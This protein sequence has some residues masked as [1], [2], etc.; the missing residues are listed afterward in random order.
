MT[1]HVQG[2]RTGLKSSAGHDGKHIPQGDARRRESTRSGS[3]LGVSWGNKLPRYTTYRYSAH[4]TAMM[5]ASAMSAKA[6]RSDLMM[7]LLAIRSS[8]RSSSAAVASRT[9]S[10]VKTTQALAHLCPV[11][12][13]YRPV[14]G[15]IVSAPRPVRE[16]NRADF[17]NPQAPGRDVL[18]DRADD[19]SR[20]DHTSRS[21]LAADFLAAIE[22]SVWAGQ[23]VALLRP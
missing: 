11:A 18:D 3:I 5:M 16:F 14:L 20:P 22:T 1:A 10:R 8:S 6:R 21:M 9:Y 23:P 19:S 2:A 17:P 4:P 12:R 13:Q 7:A 15:E